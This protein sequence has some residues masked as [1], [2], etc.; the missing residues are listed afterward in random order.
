MNKIID[1]NGDEYTKTKDVLNCQKRFYE[2][3]YNDINKIDDT[4]ISKF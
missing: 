4:H 2:N 3:L 1:E